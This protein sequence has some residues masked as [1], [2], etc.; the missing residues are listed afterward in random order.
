LRPD[1]R[2]AQIQLV[3][4]ALG[5]SG[6][7]TQ[8][9][10]HRGRRYGHLLDPRTG[11]PAQGTLSATAIARTA[12]EA[13]ALSTAMYVL[14]VEGAVGLCRERADLSVILVT[15][16]SHS[17]AVQVH[18][19]GLAENEL[20]LVSTSAVQVIQ[21]GVRSRLNEKELP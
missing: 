7:G 6:S 3:D 20:Q 21:R 11:W 14:G 1:S 17:G 4:R 9:F 5:T 18:C 2:L 12:A 19:I 16:G 13:D 8:F 10:R 15:P